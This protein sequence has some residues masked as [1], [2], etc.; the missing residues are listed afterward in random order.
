MTAYDDCKNKGLLKSIPKSKEKAK[1]SIDAAKRWI[2]EAEKSISIDA[3]NSSVICSYLAMFH[4][5]RSILYYDGMREKSHFCIAR[6]LEENYVKTKQIDQKWIASLDH[7]RETRHD[8]QYSTGFFQTKEEA[9]NAI[10]KAKDFVNEF[11]T[12]LSKKIEDDKNKEKKLS[13]KK[14][15]TKS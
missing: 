3:I 13:V 14:N 5:A 1:S 8:D 6:Y 12:L 10:E 2:E 9:T 4:A 11:D 15:K 7:A